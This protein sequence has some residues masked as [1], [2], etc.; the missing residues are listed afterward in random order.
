MSNA[1]EDVFSEMQKTVTG[2]I[3]DHGYVEAFGLIEML[4]NVV[5]ENFEFDFINQRNKRIA[6]NAQK[7]KSNESE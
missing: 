5:R 7:Q 6:E 2:V 4:R 1:I 3:K